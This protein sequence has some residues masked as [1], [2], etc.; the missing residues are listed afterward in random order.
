MQ[1]CILVRA[2]PGKVRNVLNNV[3]KVENV[4]KV[5]PVYGRYD[6]VVFV[7]APNLESIIGTSEKVNALKGVKSTETLIEG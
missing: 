7:E 4:V 2:S 6:V 1:A 5:F 3:K